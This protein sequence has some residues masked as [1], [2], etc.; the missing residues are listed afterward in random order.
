MNWIKTEDKLPDF[1]KNVLLFEKS[2]Q[3]KCDVG[4]LVSID[5]RGN[6][7]STSPKIE[8]FGKFFGGRIINKID[9]NPT[10]WC[11]IILPKE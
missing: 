8:S 9:F 4:N 7:W 3:N 11:E 2:E 1:G 6:N 5:A 10:H